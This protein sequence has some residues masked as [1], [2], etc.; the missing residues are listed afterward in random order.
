MQRKLET[1]ITIQP[2]SQGD[3][4]AILALLEQNS[5]PTEGL[6]DHVPNILAARENGVVVGCVALEIYGDSALLRSLA[7]QKNLQKHGIG[8]RLTHAAL[9]QAREHGIKSI[10]L[11][12]ETAGE[13]FPRFGFQNATRADVPATVRSSVEFTTAC[14]ESALVM[15][16]HL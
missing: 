1:S 3:I 10:Y 6:V 11:L 15:L 9:E 5:L 4:G 2:A 13:F 16:K 7:V 8:L 12:T 14:P